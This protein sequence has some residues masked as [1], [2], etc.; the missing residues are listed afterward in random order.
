MIVNFTKCFKLNKAITNNIRFLTSSSK[1][2]NSNINNNSNSFYNKRL[3]STSNQSDNKNDND[4]KENEEK[5]NKQTQNEDSKLKNEDY[6]KLTEKE[7]EEKI[8][9]YFEEIDK[10]HK[11]LEENKDEKDE[12]DDGEEMDE[13]KE[14]PSGLER[15]SLI[16]ED[17]KKNT[18]H[19]IVSDSLEISVIDG[20]A[21]FM[22]G[23][24]SIFSFFS[25]YSSYLPT[26]NIP[27]LNPFIHFC[28]EQCNYIF[29]NNPFFIVMVHCLNSKLLVT[30]LY[31]R[32]NETPIPS[33]FTKEEFLEESSKALKQIYKLAENQKS[34]ELQKISCIPVTSSLLSIRDVYY[35][36]DRTTGLD[37]S[38]QDVSIDNFEFEPIDCKAYYTISEEYLKIEATYKVVSEKYSEQC[39]ENPVTVRANWTTYFRNE[40]DE[41][42]DWKIFG[43]EFFTDFDPK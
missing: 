33:N 34:L 41:E 42:I 21:K 35:T 43:I 37:F 22:E 26:R 8:N 19:K 23:N 16:V 10:Y 6:S 29:K 2:Y 27:L 31:N 20:R 38:V 30:E 3:F 5:E 25:F 24:R 7:K 11:E 36:I 1:Q 15:S 28:K 39:K 40:A 12:N 9:K 17:D 14:F 18:T 13:S 4:K 32:L